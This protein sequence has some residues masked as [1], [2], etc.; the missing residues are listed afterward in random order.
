[1]VHDFQSTRNVLSS[2]QYD[3]GERICYHRRKQAQ[4][5]RNRSSIFTCFRSTIP[6]IKTVTKFGGKLQQ[7]RRLQPG[8]LSVAFRL[9]IEK[10]SHQIIWRRHRSKSQ[11]RVEGVVF[12]RDLSPGKSVETEFT[13]IVTETLRVFYHG[14]RQAAGLL[15]KAQL[16]GTVVSS[17]LP[18][19]RESRTL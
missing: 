18:E 5:S 2:L 4:I 19:A 17:Q 15:A 12:P 13:L 7:K 10:T 14:A 11:T 8:S 1:M 3:S 9:R 6:E 16:A